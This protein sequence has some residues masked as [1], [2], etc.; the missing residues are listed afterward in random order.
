MSL[1]GRAGGAVELPGDGCRLPADVGGG[2][3]GFVFAGA[4]G[5][6]VVHRAVQHMI[7]RNKMTI[8]LF[9]GITTVILATRDTYVEKPLFSYIFSNLHLYYSLY[10][11]CFSH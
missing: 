7:V 8:I 11:T 10:S 3:A 2:V 5:A 4:D 6:V 9:K 1:T